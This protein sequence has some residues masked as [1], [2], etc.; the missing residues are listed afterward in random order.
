MQVDKL[1]NEDFPFAIYSPKVSEE[2]LRIFDIELDF[3][4]FRK[5]LKLSQKYLMA[6]QEN[7]ISIMKVRLLKMREDLTK[8]L[9]KINQESEEKIKSITE[10]VCGKCGSLLVQEKKKKGEKKKLAK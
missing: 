3:Y 6:S 2:L 10:D 7:T 1:L 5:S 4:E 8:S 9:K